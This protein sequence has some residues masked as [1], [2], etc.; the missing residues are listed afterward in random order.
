M[1]LEVHIGYDTEIAA[2]TP[3]GPEQ[4]LLVAL[5]GAHDAPVGENDLDGK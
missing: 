4:L 1:Y 3:Q 2:A 5:I